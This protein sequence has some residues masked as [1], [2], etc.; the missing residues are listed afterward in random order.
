M[1][2]QEK[3]HSADAPFILGRAVFSPATAM[4]LSGSLADW[5]NLQRSADSLVRHTPLKITI[6]ATL[7]AKLR[8]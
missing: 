2:R 4:Q 8:V 7:H 6:D 1:W 5:P 3:N